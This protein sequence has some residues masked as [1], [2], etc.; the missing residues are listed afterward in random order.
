MCSNMVDEIHRRGFLSP[1][2]QKA[3]NTNSGL[4]SG[5]CLLDPQF[6]KKPIV[7]RKERKLHCC[8]TVNLIW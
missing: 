6:N 3:V 5:V 7:S 4:D 2:H 1:T 8:T